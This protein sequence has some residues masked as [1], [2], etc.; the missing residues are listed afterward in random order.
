MPPLRERGF[1]P[2]EQADRNH[3]HGNHDALACWE[4]P[5]N[6]RELENF[7][8]RSVIFTEGTV[9]N[10]PLSELMPAFGVHHNA[11]LQSVEREHILRVLRET[12]GV[13]SGLH[14][15]ATRLGMKRTTLQPKMQRCISRAQIT[16]ANVGSFPAG[17]AMSAF[18]RRL[19]NSA[20]GNVLTRPPF[21]DKGQCFLL[22]EA[23]LEFSL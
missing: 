22:F 2:Y 16:K 19:G 9:L 11:T 15:A 14:G 12:G 3:S 21:A 8:E 4:W 17:D 7:I 1:P 18:R 5:A 10:S 6:V 23:R 13:I 20:S